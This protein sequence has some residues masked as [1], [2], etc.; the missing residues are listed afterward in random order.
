MVLCVART[1]LTPHETASDEMSG[2]RCKGT[3][4]LIILQDLRELTVS[5]NVTDQISVHPNGNAAASG[6]CGAIVEAKFHN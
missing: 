2:C 1:F 3:Y 4:F 6:M 5:A